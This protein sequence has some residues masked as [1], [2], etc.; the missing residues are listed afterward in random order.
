MTGHRR[1]FGSIKK[2]RS[3]R[4]QASFIGPDAIRHAAPTTYSRKTDAERWLA[5]EQRRVEIA[6]PGDWTPPMGRG[7]VRAKLQDC[8]TVGEYA[9]AWLAADD[10]RPSTRALYERLIRLRI[11]PGLGNER[12]DRIDRSTIAKWWASTPKTRAD[13][14]AYSLLRTIMSA[15]ID[16][17]LTKDNPCTVKGAGRPSREKSLEPPAPEQVQAIADA[18]PP[19]WRIGVL[20]AAWC[21]LRSG[22]VR[23]LRRKDIDLAH[24]NVR[25]ERAVS[26]AGAD[27]VIGEPK[28]EAGKRTVPIPESLV[29]AIESHLALCVGAGQEA[30]VIATDEGATVHDG[31]WNRA[32]KSAAIRALAPQG[33]WEKVRGKPGRPALPDW[34][35][36]ITFHDLRHV[37]LTNAGIAGATLRE[38]QALAGHTT[39]GMAMRYQEVVHSHLAEVMDRVSAMIPTGGMQTDA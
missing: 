19:R 31:R 33:E 11:V 1:S 12:L 2:M 18:M 37:A 16:E 3:G 21:G 13:H 20:L 26:R 5:D 29:P 27:L 17:G 9:V 22:E 15:A 25:V 32:F 38:L 34:D 35:P 36:G 30:L 14:Q 10:I 7:Q 4:F 39:P 23:E 24:R 28:T 6:E 8:L